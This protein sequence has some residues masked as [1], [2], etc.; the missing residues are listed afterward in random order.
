MSGIGI[1]VKKERYRR[2]AE[3]SQCVYLVDCKIEFDSEQDME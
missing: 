1:E 3:L 2:K